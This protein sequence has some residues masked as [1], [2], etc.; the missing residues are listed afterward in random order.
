MAELI[1]HILKVIHIDKQERVLEMGI[2]LGVGRAVFNPLHHQ[3]SIREPRQ[4]V[5]RG[6]VAQLF[7]N[8]MPAFNLI[9]QLLIRALQFEPSLFKQG[10]AAFARGNIL[11]YGDSLACQ[12]WNETGLV[13]PLLPADDQAIFGSAHSPVAAISLKQLV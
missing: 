2:A 1:V 6:L 11:H 3:S 7:F 4:A 10:L 8:H 13:M 12:H 5:M 9:L